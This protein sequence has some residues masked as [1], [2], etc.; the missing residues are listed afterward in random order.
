MRRLIPQ[1]I[2]ATM[3]ILAA[4]ALVLSVSTAERISSF[5]APTAGD[6][7]VVAAYHSVIERTLNAPS[8]NYDQILNYQAPDRTSTMYAG[9][10]RVIG[11]VAYLALNPTSSTG[12]WGRGP[13]TT[14]ADAYYGP[15]RVLKQLQTFAKLTSV[16]RAGNNFIVRQVLAADTVSPGN[17]GQVL[18]TS[19]VYVADDYVTS[20]KAELTGWF[21][22]PYAGTVSNPL[23]RRVDHLTVAP[24]T[25]S[26][27]GHLSAITAPPAAKTVTLVVCGQ[28]YRVVQ[29]GQ[30]VCS[31]FG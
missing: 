12:Q 25:Y 17:P 8:F 11:Q 26:N 4:L 30:Q 28:G 14:L 20:I 10:E 15:T 13:L 27:F 21:S 1:A 29:S 18:V 7:A 9:G 24:V 23:M 22:Y 19:T 16:S 2:L 5:A 3:T 31:I 6:P